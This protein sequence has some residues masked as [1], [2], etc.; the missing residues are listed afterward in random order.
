MQS[1][2]TEEV[3]AALRVWRLPRESTHRNPSLW[4]PSMWALLLDAAAATDESTD[5][6]DPQRFLALLETLRNVLPCAYCRESYRAFLDIVDGAEP[7][8][9]LAEMI[10]EE[11]AVEVVWRLK[12][13]VNAKLGRESTNIPLRTLRRRLLSNRASTSVDVAILRGVLATEAEKRGAPYAS[14]APTWFGVLH[15]LV[16]QRGHLDGPVWVADA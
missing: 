16:S 4:G 12:T 9:G 14:V 1:T 2:P 3:L 10:A 6:E 15:D 13:L 11:R 7:S 8:A 5:S